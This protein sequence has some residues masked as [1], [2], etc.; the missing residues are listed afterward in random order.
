MKRPHSLQFKL[1]RAASLFLLFKDA[2]KT[3]QIQ[4]SDKMPLAELN[5]LKRV[6]EN[7]YTNKIK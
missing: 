2:L 3:L 6:I 5:A 4:K 7:K 1:S